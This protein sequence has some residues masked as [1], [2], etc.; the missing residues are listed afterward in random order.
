MKTMAVKEQKS[1]HRDKVNLTYMILNCH[2]L[3]FQ[4]NSKRKY[5]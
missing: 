3:L 1:T 4:R 2:D 5:K